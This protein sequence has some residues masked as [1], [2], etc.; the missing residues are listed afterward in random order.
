MG[1]PV[2][3]S[4]CLLYGQKYAAVNAFPRTYRTLLPFS[5]TAPKDHFL[6]ERSL[7]ISVQRA[8]VLHSHTLRFISPLRPQGVAPC[9]PAPC[10][11]RWAPGCRAA[12]RPRMVWTDGYSAPPSDRKP[13]N[14]AQDPRAQGTFALVMGALSRGA[15]RSVSRRD[16]GILACPQKIFSKSCNSHDIIRCKTP[17]PS[18]RPPPASCRCPWPGT[19]ETGGP[20]PRSCG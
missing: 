8:D 1:G 7:C 13:D 20:P 6:C 11:P 16:C 14:G 17:P 18:G 12:W 19:G 9:S 2:A 5:V 15:G 10:G 4:S 3:L